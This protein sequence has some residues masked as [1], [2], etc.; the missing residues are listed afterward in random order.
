VVRTGNP[1]AATQCQ[2]LGFSRTYC[3]FGKNVAVA[4][5]VS[6]VFTIEMQAGTLK[7]SSNVS[8]TARTVRGPCV[9][10]VAARW[11][12][13]GWHDG[14]AVRAGSAAGD[15]LGESVATALGAGT[16]VAL[17]AGV[18]TGVAELVDGIGAAHAATRATV[19]RTIAG[20]G[21]FLTSPA[22]PRRSPDR[23]P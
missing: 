2:K 19:S 13:S 11:T 14:V 3:P 8:A 20:S 18:A 10:N 23:Q 15:G 12:Q 22:P 16:G 1:L 21:R 6:R 4:C 9:T 5:V 17:G 7:P